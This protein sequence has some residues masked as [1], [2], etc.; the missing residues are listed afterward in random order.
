MARLVIH[1]GSPATWEVQLKPGPNLI[2]RALTSHC[3]I[4][5]PSISSSHCQILVAENAASIKDL[6]STNGTFIDGTPVQEAAL[7]N[8]QSIRLGEIEMRFY[9][10]APNPPPAVVLAADMPAALIAASGRATHTTSVT[11]ALTASQH[12]RFHPKTAAR[13]VC[14]RCHHYFCEACVAARTIEGVQHKFCRHCGAECARVQVALEAVVEKGFLG[15]VPAAFAYPLRGAG[16]IVVIVGIVIMGLLKGGQALI[17][18][19]TLRTLIFGIILEVFAGGYLF[20]YL[21]GIVHSSAAGDRELPDLPG[22]SN[23]LEDVV[24][25]FFRLLGLTLFCFGPVLGLAI[26]AK[27]S[28]QTDAAPLL[29]AA[30]G[31]GYIYFPMAF[32]AA[33]ILDSIAA[34]NPLVVIP[35]I[36]KVPL[37]YLLSLLL[38]AAVVGL[39]WF[40]G[41]T[42]RKLFPDSWTTQSMGE[43]FGMIGSLAFLSFFSLYLLVVAVHTLGLLYVTRKN[44]LGWIE[45]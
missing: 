10:D 20:T 35:S 21:Q 27:A 5:H 24:I 40:G 29:L 38:L 44:K 11:Q 22:I 4:P 7:Q 16:V 17:Q 9:S 3:Q 34:A 30:A 32:L 18:F 45:R 42:M 12:C 2:G 43:L 33:A 36:L 31:F 1:P 39:Q 25:P 15:R 41:L 13:F 19:G 37:E 14:D 6:G 23:V 28:H 8:G 26:W